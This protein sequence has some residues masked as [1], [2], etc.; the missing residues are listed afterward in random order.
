MWSLLRLAHD[1]GS[2]AENLRVRL[3]NTKDEAVNA[4][5]VEIV[6]YRHRNE[7]THQQAIRVM[8]EIEATDHAWFGE[9][10]W[11]IRPVVPE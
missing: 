10:E 11:E 6:G 4:F 1:H 5:L 2:V 3:F 9:L 7:I 8:N